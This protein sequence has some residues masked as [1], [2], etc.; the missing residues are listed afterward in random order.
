[1]V[2]MGISRQSRVKRQVRCIFGCSQPYGVAAQGC[3]IAN[4]RD[5]SRAGN[6]FRCLELRNLSSWALPHPYY[7]GISYTSVWID[8]SK[9]AKISASG[10][11]LIP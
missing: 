10:P 1:M 8:L 5:L 2:N 11:V 9:T 4:R 7:S 6:E 3:S